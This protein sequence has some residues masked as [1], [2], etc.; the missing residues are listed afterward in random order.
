M[1]QSHPKIQQSSGKP[2]R[3]AGSGAY[4]LTYNGHNFLTN[5]FTPSVLQVFSLKFMAISGCVIAAQILIIVGQWFENAKVL[6]FLLWNRDNSAWR[7]ACYEANKTFFFLL[8]NHRGISHRAIYNFQ[9]TCSSA[10]VT[11]STVH[12]FV[13]M[14]HPLLKDVHSSIGTSCRCCNLD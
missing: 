2:H 5:C 7:E 3:K 13:K 10:F 8:K 4:L 11:A 12:S 1:K 6:K 14:L 9:T